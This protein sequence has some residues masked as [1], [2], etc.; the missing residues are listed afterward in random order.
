MTA[1]VRPEV[2]AFVSAVRAELIDLDLEEIEE[3]TGGLDADLEDAIVDGGLESLGSPAEYAAE[4]RAA[5]GLPPRAAAGGRREAGSGVTSW[6]KSLSVKGRERWPAI[7]DF[8]VVI[9]PAWWVLRAFVAGALISQ[10]LGFGRFAWVL[11]S[12]LLTVP[13]VQLERR[14]F[15]DQGRGQYLLI[16]AGNTVAALLLIPALAFMLP[17]GSSSYV[18]MGE[19]MIPSN[20]LWHNGVEVRNVL[21]Y[22]SQGRPLYGVQLFDENGNPLDVG[23]SARTPLTD[24][25]TIG[26]DGE[27]RAIAQMPGRGPANEVLWNVYPLP[28]VASRETGYDAN[29]DPQWTAI[30]A[31]VYPVNPRLAGAA[32]YPAPTPS[33]DVVHPPAVSPSPVASGSALSP[34][35]SPVSPSPTANTPK[36]SP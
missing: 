15:A 23:T 19:P 35:P 6:A 16:A 27:P 2:A 20:G 32:N 34:S 3:L 28:Q 17:L 11:L 8:L 5:A 25:N 30:A 26:T 24:D 22:D 13:S 4:L 7:R 1:T 10:V 29:G 14:R 31:P 36:P 21:P 18:S 33:T 12:L 9:A